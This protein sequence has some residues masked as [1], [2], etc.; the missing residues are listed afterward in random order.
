MA[1]AAVP[2]FPAKAAPGAIAITVVISIATFMQVLDSTIANVA[3]PHMQASL[4][5]AADTVTWVLTSYIV[6]TAIAMPLTGWLGDAIGRRNLILISIIGFTVTS[7]LC[8][9]ARSLE[10]MV[11]FRIFQGAFGAFVI[12]VGQSFILDAFPREKQGQAMAYWGIGVML[13]PVMGPVL[14]GWLTDSFNWRYVFFINVPVGI[15]CLT[16]ALA[17]L[18]AAPRRSRRFD[19]AGF[20]MLGVGLGALQLMLDRGQQLDWFESWEVRIEAMVAVAALWMFAVHMATARSPLFDRRLFLDKNAVY[21][22]GFAVLIGVMLMSSS[23]LLPVMLQTL[24]GYPVLTSG[25]VL[26]PRG[27]GTM[28]MMLIVGQ[29]IARVDPRKV[30]AFGLVLIA[31]GMWMMSG[32]SSLVGRDAIIISGVIQGM[33]MGCMFVPLNTIAFATLPPMLRT[34]AS[35]IYTLLR[36]I[37]GSIGVSLCVA[38]LARQQQVVHSDLAAHLTP[39]SLT[40]DP[41]VLGAFG[42]PGATVAAVM[43]GMVNA[44]AAMVAYID[45]FRLLAWVTLLAIPIVLVVRRPPTMAAAPHP[46][47]E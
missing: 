2:Q 1:S 26:A 42:A 45:V 32:F 21:G 28:V 36:N 13:G 6:A 30:M 41:S 14:G 8:G 19:I 38:I 24:L 20:A 33:G 17:V 39:Y 7:A 16:G 37:G 15:I 35:S 29:I 12:P 47:G 18:P 31:I 40:L 43:D 44:Q 25:L 9:F 23:A 22:F 10:E 5:A 27:I 11:I 46:A 4:G 34:D 3:L